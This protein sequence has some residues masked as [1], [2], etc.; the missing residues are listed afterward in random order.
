MYCAS[1]DAANEYAPP[2]NSLIQSAPCSIWS[3]TAARASS[4][5]LTMARPSGLS[6]AAARR[7]TPGDAA[8]RDLRARSVDE[9][10]VDR[11]ADVDVGVA[12]VVAAHVAHRREAGAQIRLRV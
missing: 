7:R 10:L 2:G 11:V 3:R 6:S 5:L 4:T 9:P 1:P 12:V 8:R